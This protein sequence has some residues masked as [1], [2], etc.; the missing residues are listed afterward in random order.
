MP[1]VLLEAAQGR[2]T[3]PGSRSS[4]SESRSAV[5]G[6][7]LDQS[8]QPSQPRILERELAHESRIPCH[9]RPVG[10]GDQLVERVGVRV[11]DGSKSADVTGPGLLMGALGLF[12]GVFW[13][14]RPER[15]IVKG[16]PCPEARAP[17]LR[18]ASDGPIP[19]RDSATAR[20]RR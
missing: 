15:L 6:R 4:R 12:V 16:R 9:P 14:R 18:D 13:Q 3:R 7:H 2:S 17:D 19:N 20:P 10:E 11:A 1:T 5:R 8:G